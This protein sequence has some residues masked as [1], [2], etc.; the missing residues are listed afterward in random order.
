MQSDP[1]SL[2]SEPCKKNAS[3]C[4][5]I[6]YSEQKCDEGSENLSKMRCL[7]TVMGFDGKTYTLRPLVEYQFSTGR[8]SSIPFHNSICKSL[9]KRQG[10]FILKRGRSRDRVDEA[11]VLFQKWMA[12]LMSLGDTK[13]QN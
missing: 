3:S 2:K 8:G 9:K 11:N 4:D 7:L 6:F 5:F 13:M 12:T 10:N 1:K